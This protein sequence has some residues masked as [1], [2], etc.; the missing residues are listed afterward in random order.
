M[1]A[2]TPKEIRP[3]VSD[4]D[5]SALSRG[6][7]LLET[8]TASVTPLTVK[9]LAEQTGLPRPTVARI[10]S[11]LVNAGYVRQLEGKDRYFPTTRSLELANTFLSHFDMRKA[12]R[13]LLRELAE[14]C[15]TAVHLCLRNRLDMVVIESVRP[16]VGPITVR[17]G[18]G[19]RL[20]LARSAI[21]R[22]H[23]ASLPPEERDMLL[24]SLRISGA[25]EG[26]DLRAMMKKAVNELS[27]KGFVSAFGDW[28]SDIN[29][30]AVPLQSP[31]GER[32]AINCGGPAFLCSPETL[33]EDI[34]PRLVD[35]AR[36]AQ[37]LS[38]KVV[39]GSV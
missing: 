25:N 39:L 21:G 36:K 32:F 29:A 16:S 28:H 33:L 38:G 23:L 19:D 30:V 18:L 6:L 14:E 8:I 37:A 5:V 26:I 13:P 31:S 9:E 34:G 10:A 11:T 7:A 2:T 15:G 1:T 20:Q 22:A 35:T 17:L 4:D 24:E 3:K 27:E 12:V